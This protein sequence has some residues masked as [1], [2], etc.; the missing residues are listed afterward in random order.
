[1]RNLLIVIASNRAQPNDSLF[2]NLA[3]FAARGTAIIHHV[4]TTD[5]A[6]ARNVSLTMAH[7]V[8]QQQKHDM[9]LMLDDD[10]VF[11]DSH[12]NA[13]L[14]AA[15]Q[16]M[17]P[18]SA[19]YVMASGAL[20]ARRRNRKWLTGLGFL[21]I[22]SDVLCALADDSPRFK[23]PLD[24]AIN[25]LEIIE[26]TGTRIVTHEDG[27]REWQGED[28]VFCE[29]LGG[30]NLAPVSVGHLKPKVLQPSPDHIKAFLDEQEK[31]S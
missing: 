10:M 30:I 6:L 3:G 15:A 29:R 27:T 24:G 28:F 8:L 7:A 20:A 14:G 13:I 11:N 31:L 2:K 25:Q 22:P 18:T 1:M 26:F 23:C 19:C 9:V 5:V 17:R 16:S 4:G 21:A 12:V